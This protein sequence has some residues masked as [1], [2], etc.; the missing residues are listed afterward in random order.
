VA[1]LA[2]FVV[3]QYRG[4]G[5][6]TTLLGALGA[7]GS[8]AGIERFVASVLYENAE[9]RGVL[10]K[11]GARWG[12]QDPGIISASIDVGAAGGLVD[13]ELRSRLARTARDVVTAGGLALARRVGE[14][15]TS[16]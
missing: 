4:R 1:E 13:G 12:V 16:S 10:D 8:S 2:F 7:A 5:L 9:M 15:G 14:A 3:E 6:A 11:A